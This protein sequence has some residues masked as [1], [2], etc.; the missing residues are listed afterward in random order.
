MYQRA[1]TETPSMP[2]VAI[3]AG[4]F[5]LLTT[6]LFFLVF[7]YRRKY[8]KERDPEVPTITY[9]PDV[10]NSG[11]DGK[12]E[13]D[14]PLYSQSVVAD[15]EKTPLKRSYEERTQNEYATLDEMCPGPSSQGNTL[16]FGQDN[17]EVPRP[18]SPFKI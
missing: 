17:Y 11:I 1:E 8:M 15:K 9:Y 4:G 2:I 16:S 18:L 5:L 7:H 10:K 6:L 12:N 14:N 3:I 13:F